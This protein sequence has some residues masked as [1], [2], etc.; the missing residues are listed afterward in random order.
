MSTYLRN[1]SRLNLVPVSTG[2]NVT[3]ILSHASY[4]YSWATTSALN[5]ARDSGT[6]CGTVDNSLSF[7]G[8]TG[9]YLN[10]TEK[11][12]GLSWATTSALNQARCCLAGCGDVNNALS[13]GGITGPMVATTEKWGGSSW[14]TTSALNQAR[15][16]LAGCGTTSAALSFGGWTS[17][18]NSTEKWSGSSWVTTSA[19]NKARHSLSGCGN[20]NSA[21]SFGGDSGAIT[22]T[23]EKWTGSSWA[24][25][26]VLNLARHYLAGCG[27]TTNA[28]SFGGNVSAPVATTEKW[29]SSNWVTTSSLNVARAGLVGCGTITDA[30][31]FGG[32]ISVYSNITER[33]KG[34]LIPRFVGSWTTTSVLN[35]SRQSLAGCGTVD[36][37]LS[38]GGYTGVG[39]FNTTEKWTS[40]SWATT[41]ILNQARSGLA[42]CGDTTNALSF[43][44]FSDNFAM[45]STT[46]KW[47]G[48]TWA[49]TA[50][51]NLPRYRLI[52]CG[53]ST[54]ALCFGGYTG[55]TVLVTM[56]EKWSGSTWTTT[57]ALNQVRFALAGCGTV[58]SALS[59]G[60]YTA[61]AV[62]TTEKWSGSSWTTTSALN[63]ARY[64]LSGCGNVSN[65]L[66]FGGQNTAGST[67]NTTEKWNEFA[68]ITTASMTQVREGLAGCGTVDNALSFGGLIAAHTNTTE[69]WSAS[70]FNAST[71]MTTGSLN[72]GRYGLAGCG[73][74]NNS[75]S[76]GG[77]TGSDVFQNTTEKWS[78]NTWATTT[79]LIQA[80]GY[81]SGGGVGTGTSA[82]CFGGYTAN[83]VVNTTEKWSGSN[84]VTTS[85][86]NQARNTMGGCGTTT[87]ALSFGGA[88]GSQVNT[89]EKWNSTIWTTTSSLNQAK[90]SLS[91]CGDVNSALSFCGTTGTAAAVST[92]E[93]WSGLVWATTATLNQARYNSSGCG[94]TTNALCFGGYT[95]SASVNTTEKWSG[96]SWSTSSAL[97]IAKRQLAGCGTINAALSIGGDTGA[98]VASTERWGS[99]EIYPTPIGF[100]NFIGTPG[101]SGFGVG[102][103]PSSS[104]PLGMVGMTGYNII[105][106][107]NYG[108]Y[109]YAD[110]SIMVYVPKFYYRIAH[111]SNFTYATY[112]VNSIDIKGMDIFLT[113]GSANAAGY[114]LHR[115]FIDGGVE[116]QGF[117]R[118]KYKCSKVANGS[119][120][121]AASI[122]NGLP[123]SSAAAHNPFSG[124]TGGADYYYSAVDLAHRRDGVNGNVNASSIFF[125]SS[126]FL[127]S[128]IAMLSLAHGQ[129]VSVLGSGTT[130]CAW[131]NATYNYPK[132]CN[133]TALK[134][135]DDT[136][137][138][139][140][141]DGYGNC[142]KT[143]SAG[144]GGGAGNVFAK[145]SHNGQNC[146]S[147]DDNGLMYEISIGITS[148][149]T[150][151]Y[152][153]KQ[154]TAMKTFTA[155]DNSVAT[156]HW[157][158]AGIALMD[159][160]NPLPFGDDAAWGFFGNGANQ[161]LSEATSG[162]AWL[163]TGLGLP[164][165][166]NG[167]GAT[168]TDLFGKDGLYKKITDKLCLIVAHYWSNT[169]LAGTFSAYFDYVRDGSDGVVGFRCACYHV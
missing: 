12:S 90:D 37:A 5:Q 101:F 40:S 7:G 110:G 68:W 84:W 92:T 139:W 41:S 96:S 142:G 70:S 109:Q 16:W 118:D 152:A 144:Y 87:D 47:S 108:N 102:V 97:N 116:K 42:G 93:K 6:G 73:D 45:L 91:G 94:T 50:V 149:G 66:S 38:F 153:A 3:S 75:L 141:T 56:S 81:L 27:D 24:T 49:T 46:E 55:A 31:S 112:G 150:N 22:G 29:T 20:V 143:G 14:A 123:L 145:S 113:T 9:A 166:S 25:T 71:W 126:Q 21:L 13:F 164:K 35:A 104:L 160:I 99:S 151:I 136:S 60:G 133:N 65:V 26:T 137:V 62:N 8:T 135:C 39:A 53:T 80:K 140:Q 130:N 82:L 163:L 105:G 154:S 43:G 23:T 165:D 28:L 124:L 127:R 58:T 132:G 138:I 19:L 95:A 88:T 156:D 32:W 100:G 1:R 159:Q 115:A 17:Y 52:G 85:T 114:A 157:G 129:A 128:A 18:L 106:H 131:Y 107:D 44:G 67:V 158:A 79:A 148:N 161:V 86:L 61:S 121:T 57:A 10:S 30:L 125:C 2:Y 74:V 72:T 48:S 59:S 89:T 64:Y 51:L 122:K 11:W 78:N 119:G 63:V 34:F 162:N 77:A 134:D 169:S 15:D 83:A 98:V 168:G 117:F 76:F 167:L 69:K 54:D 155:G 147:A 120:Y 146:G 33:W 111:A 36:N 103:C 4:V